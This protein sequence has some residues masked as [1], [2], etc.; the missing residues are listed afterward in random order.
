MIAHIIGNYLI[1]KNLI[2]RE[3]LGDILREQDKVRV[4]LGL[5]AV[6][7]G[8]MT[9]EE[10]EEVNKLQA[11]Q[12][13][14]FGDI[15]IDN[16]YLTYGQ[17]EGLLKKQGNAYLSFAQVLDNMGLMTVDQLEKYVLDFGYENQYSLS[18][19]EDLKSNDA[20]RILP[21]YLPLEAESYLNLAG[22]A[23][24]TIMRCVDN[25]VYPMKAF[26]AD[27]LEVDNA[28]VQKVEGEKSFTCAIAGRTDSLKYPASVF[29]KEEFETVDED[30]L[31]SIGELLNCINGLYASEL[32]QDS[33]TLE[34]LPPHYETGIHEISAEKMLILP[35]IIDEKT[36]YFAIDNSQ[37]IEMK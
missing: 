28:A 23:V 18:D 14:R 17:V 29:G 36:I 30:A 16:G 27:M 2:T 35:L 7:E 37:M 12:D 20:T 10:A 4:K 33:V 22:I 1:H 34:L 15:A 19:L 13:K 31:D 32:S 8:F 9:Q 21:Y 24:R 3:Q 26:F 11:V 6:A 25:N 5:I